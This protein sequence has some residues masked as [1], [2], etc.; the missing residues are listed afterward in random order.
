MAQG[1]F[2]GSFPP[3][4]AELTI[5]FPFAVASYVK[6]WYPE[7]IIDTRVFSGNTAPF[8]LGCFAGKFVIGITASIQPVLPQSADCYFFS[9]PP[10]GPYAVVPLLR[11]QKGGKRK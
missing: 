10:D 5:L 11:D 6:K 3:S 1:A 2:L 7:T 9:S 4:Y 8:C